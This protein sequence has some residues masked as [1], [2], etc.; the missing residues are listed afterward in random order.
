MSILAGDLLELLTYPRNEVSDNRGSLTE[1]LIR[2]IAANI[3]G[4]G[5]ADE[6]GGL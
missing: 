4:E 3:I 5:V 1:V 6:R 2:E